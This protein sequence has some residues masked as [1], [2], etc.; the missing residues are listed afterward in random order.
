VTLDRGE[1]LKRLSTG[2]GAAALG[3][4][5]A[6]EALAA[7]LE[8]GGGDFPPHPRWKFVFVS[9]LTTSPLFVPLQYGIQDACA[10]VRCQYRWTGS[11]TASTAELVK[12]VDSAVSSKADGIALT[13]VNAAALERPI[14]A[15]LAAGI[16]VVGYHAQSGSTDPRV[17][18]VGQNAYA[19]GLQVGRRI[20]ALVR[21]GEVALF[22]TERG[23]PPVEPRVRGVL[24]GLRR[25]GAPVRASVVLTTR[26][27]YE[28]AA[29][30]DRY[31]TKQ[32]RL[33]G[34]FA[35][36]LVAT[37]GVGR[38]VARHG[39]SAKGVRAGGY[40]ALP[41]TLKLIKDGRLAF[42]LDEQPYLQGFVPAL[43]LFL[44]RLSG[45]LVAPSDTDLPLVF[46]TR[47]NLAPYL[48]KTR[49]EGSSS[50]QRY[51]IQ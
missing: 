29:R 48:A 2:A 26:D 37:D 39:L 11:D 13:L 27:P 19:A 1:L 31:V 34:L 30:I 21:T 25:S 33:R 44:A 3:G 51:P 32:K 38:A 15:A 8:S 23:V 9:H 50:K 36:E 12:A 24:A 17:A 4:L 7:E 47:A 10:L 16:P 40:G 46:V 41:A 6:P 14:G 43:Q 18:F 5:L 20:A 42:T 22:V 28:A 49:Y 35:L 45:G